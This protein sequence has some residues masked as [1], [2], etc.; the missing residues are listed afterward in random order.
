MTWVNDAILCPGGSNMTGFSRRSFLK[1]GSAA[2]VAAGAIS[3]LPAL[4]ALVGAVESQGPGDANAAEGAV[5]DAEP[6]ALSEPLIAHV[7]DLATG[8]IGLF[9]GTRGITLIDPQL[10]ARLARAL[11]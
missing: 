9:S 8:E 3:S 7:R 5:A 1:T 10:A 2:A 6:A 11:R 4:P